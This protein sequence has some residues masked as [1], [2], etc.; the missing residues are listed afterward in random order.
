MNKQTN[1]RAL[2]VR[3]SAVLIVKHIVRT[4]RT[5]YAQLIDSSLRT[6][7]LII[8]SAKFIFSPFSMP[9]TLIIAVQHK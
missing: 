3:V 1:K 6:F 5:L 9:R 8:P 7:F 4:L 2:T